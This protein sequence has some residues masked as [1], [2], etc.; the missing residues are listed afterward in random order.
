MD[1]ITI[2]EDEFG[3]KRQVALVCVSENRSLLV[4]IRL[5]WFGI[6]SLFLRRSL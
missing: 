6:R 2:Q 4:K 3:E 1:L 5:W